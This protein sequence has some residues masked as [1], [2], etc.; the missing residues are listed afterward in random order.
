MDYWWCRRTG[1]RQ[2]ARE[3]RSQREIDIFKPLT[4]EACLEL[5]QAEGLGN[6]G[7]EKEPS[8]V[9]N[10]GSLKDSELELW[11][12]GLARKLKFQLFGVVNLKSFFDLGAGKPMSWHNLL[13]SYTIKIL[14]AGQEQE[15]EQ[16]K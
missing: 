16:A 9:S 7:W 10:Y 6:E 14:S 3:T 5:I 13:K 2:R 15:R 4:E 1:K 12:Y 8:N 11:W